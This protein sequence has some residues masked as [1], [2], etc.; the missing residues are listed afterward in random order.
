MRKRAALNFSV[1]DQPLRDD[2]REL[3]ALLGEVLREQGPA[4]LYRQV[5]AVRSASLRRRD[6]DRHA[7][8]RL[9]SLLAQVPPGRALPLIRAFSAYFFLVN[10]AE[11][12]HRIRRTLD[13]R[14]DGKMQPGSW[15]AAAQ[16]L[17]AAGL[18]A[19][20]LP[21]L[22]ERLQICPVF[23]AH[24]TEAT[25]RALL[26]KEQRI[27]RALM[28]RLSPEHDRTALRARLRSEITAAW[29]TEEQ[30]SDRPSV[31]DEVEHVLFYLSE[32]IYRVVP[33]CYADLQDA[34]TQQFGAGRQIRVPPFLSFGSWVGGDMDGNPNV[35]PDTLR[36]TLARHQELALR[37]YRAEVRE[38]FGA[39][40]QTSSLIG[41]AP[42]VT[43][44]IAR[45]RRQMP[46]VFG[47]ITP[48]YHG[49]P[50]RI[51]LWFISH[52][53]DQ[54]AAGGPR[55]YTGPDEYLAD[56]QL[57]HDSLE[58]HHGT[59]AGGERV[60]RLIQRVQ[61]F[62]FHLA[63]L[64]VRQHAAVHRRCVA[65]L[66][67]HKDF[68]E[69]PASERTS[70]LRRA[71]TKRMRAP[72]RAGQETIRTLDVQRAIAEARKKYGERAI[73]LTIISMAQG[74]DDALAV[75]LLARAAGTAGPR[76]ET[77]LDIT[78]LFETV[79]DLAGAADTLESLWR[80]P[81]YRRHLRRRGNRQYVMLGYSDSNKDSGLV[82]ARWALHAAQI[83]IL[84]A[85]R[86]HKL[87]VTLFHG[88][89][90]SISRGGG[91]PRDAILAE[92]PGAVDGRL[93]L[94]EQGEI[95]HAKYGLRGLAT[96][97]LELMGSAVLERLNPAPAPPIPE[98]WSAA[99]HTAARAGRD[100]YRSLV[101]GD[102]AFPDYFRKATPIDVIERL[103]IGSRP[104]RRTG[105][106]GIED[107]R[108]IPWVF[109]WTQSRH[110]LPGWF[111][112]GS[113]LVAA[114][115]EVGLRTLQRMARQWRFFDNLLADAE[116]AHAKADLD[117]AQR[118]AQLAGRSGERIFGIIRR[119]HELAREQIARVRGTVEPLTHD[120]VLRRALW[121]RNP[122]VDPMSFLQVDLLRRWRASGR[123]DKKLEH[124]LIA[125]VHGI[126]RG[127]Q[128]TG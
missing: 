121:L 78:P 86:R 127:M 44:R 29:Q 77:P 107:L 114:E 126:A 57:I 116:M 20:A 25:R 21:D 94:T 27:A 41:V 42:A 82:S 16:T 72:K 66:L 105:T 104:S 8:R 34:L 62:G 32:V 75:M 13:Y 24:P 36:A 76:G 7:A 38:L 2:V 95:I 74:P 73:G 84:A 28:D 22:L 111:G 117:I 58:R 49:M 26:T 125:T 11:R 80:E 124:A 91:R 103:P 87:A 6:G 85:A 93:R 113:A 9:D 115:K 108:A 18:R 102:P 64:D 17:A 83:E 40:T 97:T 50:Y 30:L 112:V 59:H 51:L 81:A 119:E 70:L 48:R 55:H 43:R 47:E 92:P 54:T 5:E 10:M 89:G 101:Y 99:M 3:G 33:R 90:G 52:R 123:R 71:L 100:R 15:P 110:L 106:A 69:L 14:R 31:A 35:G 23:T 1:R 53:L 98:I 67:Q 118:Y 60:L 128:N 4:G 96:R 68:P 122:Y 88:R 61:T 65:E 109:A 79:D 56:L 37:R 120:P 63:A 12:I 19:S 45:Y 46:G 39:L